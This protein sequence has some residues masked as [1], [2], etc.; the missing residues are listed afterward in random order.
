MIP[1]AIDAVWKQLKGKFKG[2]GADWKGKGKNSGF[3]SKGKGKS[4]SKDKGKGKGFKGSKGK[5]PFKGFKGAKGKGKSKGSTGATSSSTV[6]CFN[7][8]R[9]GHMAAQCW[10]RGSVQGVLDTDQYDE[11]WDDSLWDF[12][13]DQWQTEEWDSNDYSEWDDQWQ[14]G[15]W[16][17]DPS[18]ISQFEQFVSEPATQ[19]MSSTAGSSMTGTSAS[20]S[21]PRP[22]VP[23]AS[24][25][26]SR[27]QTIQFQHFPSTPEESTRT[28]SQEPSSGPIKRAIWTIYS[29]Y[30][31]QTF[32]RQE[33]LLKLLMDSG[34]VTHVIPLWFAEDYPIQPLKD[35]IRLQAVTGKDITVYGERLIGFEIIPNFYALI[36]FVVCDI[37]M[38]ILSVAQLTEKDVEVYLARLVS[39]LRF[40][41]VK[42][43]LVRDGRT[44]FLCPHRVL[45]YAEAFPEGVLAPVT[46]GETL[47]FKSGHTDF[48]KVRGSQ[49]IRIHKR[50]RKFYF[51]PI[52]T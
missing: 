25:P 11:A 7:C 14:E 46:Y 52:S 35:P 9:Q 43:P 26:V 44:F 45:P 27:V 38:P 3:D 2:K 39:G 10:F 47:P 42:V 40:G 24:N 33:F 32:Q 48:W 23:Q 20:P 29:H 22:P 6:V 49:L 15:G 12:D 50:P 17:D 8:G 37:Q 30:D 28:E 13:Y 31:R 16:Q 5:Q 51:N 36:Q 18:W 4:K 34:A 21:Q 1:M 19:S 41:D